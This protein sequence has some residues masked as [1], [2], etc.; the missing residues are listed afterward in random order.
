MS[1]RIYPEARPEHSRSGRVALLLVVAALLAATGGCGRGRGVGSRGVVI[2]QRTRP[3]VTREKQANP[4]RQ[5][6]PARPVQIKLHEDHGRG[7]AAFEVVNLKDA[8]LDKLT[9]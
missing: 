6:R 1:N 7:P 9:K 4:P 5:P 8:D 2:A 3:P